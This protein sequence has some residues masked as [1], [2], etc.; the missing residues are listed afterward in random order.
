[1]R[2]PRVLTRP[3][4]E[5]LLEDAH[6]RVREELA[7]LATLEANLQRAR[8][9]HEAALAEAARNGRPAARPLRLE[10]VRFEDLRDAGLSVTQAARVLTVRDRGGLESLSDLG[11]VPGLSQKSRAMLRHRLSD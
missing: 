1:M 6:W 2:L 5:R 9:R 3:L 4:E 10:S 7:R 11:K 8:A